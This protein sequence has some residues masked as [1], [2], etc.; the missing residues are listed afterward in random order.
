MESY[1]L[2]H[3]IDQ[4]ENVT[5]TEHLTPSSFSIAILSFPLEPV[6]IIIS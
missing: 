6:P 2:D 1:E 5:T 3:R 4:I